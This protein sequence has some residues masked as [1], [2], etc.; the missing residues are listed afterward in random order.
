MSDTTLLRG[1]AA[2]R[3]SVAKARRRDPSNTWARDAYE[4]GVEGGGGASAVAD[5]ERVDESTIRDRYSDERRDPT[6]SQCRRGL[7][8]Y[9]MRALAEWLLDA[10]DD[11]ERN[12]VVRRTG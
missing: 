11:E 7:G 1:R 4:A 12:D 2:N 3:P 10:A 6:L 5:R 9:G 8:P